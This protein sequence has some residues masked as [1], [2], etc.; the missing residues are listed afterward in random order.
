MQ[1]TAIMWRVALASWFG[2]EMS[3]IWGTCQL[4]PL[5]SDQP[6]MKGRG[7]VQQPEAFL[8]TTLLILS[9]VASR[10]RA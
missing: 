9:T 2:T 7:N 5:W 10:L 3:C 8:Q 1:V 6:Q 4:C